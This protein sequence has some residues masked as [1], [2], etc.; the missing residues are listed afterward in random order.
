MDNFKVYSIDMNPFDDEG[1]AY[2]YFD[3]GNFEYFTL[4]K[5]TTDDNEQND[6]YIEYTEETQSVYSNNIS[7]ILLDNGIEFAFDCF[8]ESSINLKSPIRLFYEITDDDFF[9][10][11]KCLNNIFVSQ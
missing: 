8:I 4:C 10:L 7:Y 11:K 3:L 6:I 1:L 2:I 9:K 5:F